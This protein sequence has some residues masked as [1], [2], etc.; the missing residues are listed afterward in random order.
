MLMLMSVVMFL[1]DFCSEQETSRTSET[2]WL[3]TVLT[4]GTL[5]DKMAAWTLMIQEAPVHNIASLEHL[6]AM[7]AKKGRR[8]ALMAL[9]R[10]LKMFRHNLFVLVSLG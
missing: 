7:V 5:K 8:E 4:S 10:L 3:R 9:G 6:I 2:S 1:F